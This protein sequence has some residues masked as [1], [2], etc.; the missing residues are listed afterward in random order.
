MKAS[1]FQDLILTV[2]KSGCLWESIAVMDQK[3]ADVSWVGW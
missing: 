3:M 1:L 2:A